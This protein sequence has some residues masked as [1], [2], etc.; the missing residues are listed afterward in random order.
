MFEKSLL[1][2]SSPTLGFESLIDHI[3]TFDLFKALTATTT[4]TAKAIGAR[5]G[6]ML[7]SLLD[8]FIERVQVNEVLGSFL[9]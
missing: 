4:A 9:E 2:F 7:H 3:Q 6:G 1:S 8:H 5:R